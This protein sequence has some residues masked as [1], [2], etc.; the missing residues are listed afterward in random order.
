MS[1]SVHFSASLPGVSF[2][3]VKIVNL[4]G[5]SVPEPIRI[6][7]PTKEMEGF[8]VHWEGFV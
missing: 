7:R 5:K 4:H 1:F 8:S 2:I 6:V 3:L